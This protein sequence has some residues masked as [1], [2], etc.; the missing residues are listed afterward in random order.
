MRHD[1][2]DGEMSPEHGAISAILDMLEGKGDE[3][4]KNKYGPK[5]EPKSEAPAHGHVVTV[6]VHGGG[7]KPAD[8][9]GLSHEMLEGL[10]GGD[11]DDDG[12]E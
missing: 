4:M 2:D 9:S 12:E 7:A 3:L 1:D 5:E 10:L 11:E 8:D 6:T